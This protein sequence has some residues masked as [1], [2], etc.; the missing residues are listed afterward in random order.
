MKS[1]QNIGEITSVAKNFGNLSG[2]VKGTEEFE[3]LRRTI[4]GLNN[5]DEVTKLFNMTG[6]S[7]EMAEAVLE[8]TRFAQTTKQ[9]TDALDVA[10][11]A[12]VDFGTK[13]K[14]TF[15][16]IGPSIK[17]FLTS[18]AGI[19]TIAIAG[20]VAFVELGEAIRK[21]IQGPSYDELQSTF[22][23]SF[24]EYEAAKS[25]VESVQSELS[26]VQAQID[27]INST[28]LT[29]TSQA[30]LQNLQAQK[31]ELEEM[32]A[33]KE[34]IAYASQQ[35]SAQDALAASQAKTSADHLMGIGTGIK[36]EI[37]GVLGPAMEWYFNDDGFIAKLL[38]NANILTTVGNAVVPYNNYTDQDLA[39][40]DAST[41]E[42]LNK[43]KEDI[44]KWLSS[45]DARRASQ[46]NR[47]NV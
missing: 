12:T 44:E 20:T 21:A 27:E 9:V 29:F 24:G 13:A 41:L 3:K 33:L 37:D 4:Q 5:V 42:N 38:R 10:S 39:L 46:D 45:D 40:M 8:N 28:P 35:Q 16:G 26:N 6:V 17:S 14:N 11:D 31:A 36:S 34:N 43:Q 15:K 25:E 18:G 32:L 1:I 7:S 19:A 22:S 30:E 2:L 47:C 23:S